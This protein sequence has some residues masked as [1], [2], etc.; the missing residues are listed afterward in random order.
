MQH[1]A[2][3]EEIRMSPETYRFVMSWN[4]YS[5]PASGDRQVKLGL[6]VRIPEF[7]ECS[8]KNGIE[9]LHPPSIPYEPSK[10]PSGAG[11]S[12]GNGFGEKPKPTTGKVIGKERWQTQS[13]RRA[14]R[15]KWS[16]RVRQQKKKERI[17]VFNIIHPNPPHVCRMCKEIDESRK[18][19][20]LPDQPGMLS[21]CARYMENRGK[22]IL[23]ENIR[24]LQNI[25]PWILESERKSHPPKVWAM[26]ALPTL[27]RNDGRFLRYD[28]D[29]EGKLIRVYSY[30]PPQLIPEV[31]LSHDRTSDDAWEDRSAFP[32]MWKTGELAEPTGVECDDYVYMDAVPESDIKSQCII[33]P[34]PKWMLG[35]M[36]RRRVFV[37][38]ETR[39]C[40]SIRTEYVRVWKRR[41]I[42]H[43]ELL[44]WAWMPKETAFVLTL[45]ARRV[46]VRFRSDDPIFKYVETQQLINVRT[47]DSFA[48]EIKAESKAAGIPV[49]ELCAEN[50]IVVQSSTVRTRK[51]KRFFEAK[52]LEERMQRR[53]KVFLIR[54]DATEGKSIPRSR[55]RASAP[56]LMI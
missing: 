28:H 55:E 52:R 14:W 17:A 49:D 9:C 50:T 3:G 56:P 1:K 37:G 30:V 53:L 8:L 51:E 39:Y 43:P 23:P 40:E 27:N 45:E 24:A 21:L 16:R 15:K 48:K 20:K 44:W 18:H 2:N 12:E 13:S 35:G 33:M 31:A 36:T 38:F 54:Q 46:A 6:H 19:C 11:F 29:E 32:D 4:Y 41:D 22:I 47:E 42:S 7:R 10:W 26:S 25:Y 5:E 34:K